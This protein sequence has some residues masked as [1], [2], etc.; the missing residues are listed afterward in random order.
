MVR[1]LPICRARSL[2]MFRPS[3]CCAWGCNRRKHTG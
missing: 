3:N 2:C 1:I